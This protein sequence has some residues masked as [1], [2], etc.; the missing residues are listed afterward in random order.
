MVRTLRK[1][2]RGPDVLRW[3]AFLQ[4]HGFTPGPLD[5]VFN[6]TTVGATRAFQ[7]KQ[8]L[9]PDA[10]VGPRTL[11][12][13]AALGLRSLR[14]LRNNEVTHGLTVEAKRILAAHRHEP[15]G[16]EFPFQLGGVQ[17][18]ARI[19]EHYH[20]PGGALRPWGHHPGVSLFMET[21]FDRQIDAADDVT[22]EAPGAGEEPPDAPVIASRGVIVIDP[23]HGGTTTVG[24]SSPNNARGPS[25]MLEKTLCLEL[26]QLVR[27]Q[28][29]DRAIDVRVEL[30]RTSDENLGLAERA[31]RAR[32]VQ[33]DAFLSIHFN[34]FNGQARGVEAHVRPKS[35]G[36]VN[37]DDDRRFAQSVV[38]AVF[39]AVKS[40][41]AG[42]S[43]RG[44]K[45]TN[46]GVL[47]DDLLGNTTAGGASLACLL[48]V[49]FLDVPAVD[50][51]FNTGPNAAAV[52]TRVAAA[53]A[54]SLLEAI[55]TAQHP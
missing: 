22:G 35:G 51:L 19:E 49:E 16:T 11:E 46:L 21:D 1:G 15:Y 48:E 23:G 14:R 39:E 44:V 17:Y 47:R 3:Q 8:G 10:V 41:D 12:K 20:P 38:N 30:T 33:A 24:H 4:E 54:Q 28:I 50:A 13:A 43:N 29:A 25:G 55:A 45:E 40:F 5:G 53:I 6:E 27:A 34:G 26:A 31:N 36:N 18:V 37:F 52:R 42:T 2:H 9:D 7:T 32:E